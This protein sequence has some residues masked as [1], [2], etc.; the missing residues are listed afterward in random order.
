M[1]CLVLAQPYTFE[2]K[3]A[4]IPLVKP[5]EALVRVRR[6]GVC[7]T[8][9]HAFQGQQPYFNYPR[10][11]GHELAV[12]IVDVG[13][14]SAGLKNGN[15]CVVI[16]Y[17]SCG[18]CVACHAGKTNCCTSLKVLGVHVDG[19]LQDYLSVPCANLIK[20]ER[21]TLEQAALIENQSIGAHAVRRAEIKTGETVLVLGAGP[22]G[23]GI[24]QFAKLRGARVIAVD[25]NDQRL[26]FCRERLG[27][28]HTL[29]AKHDPA[30]EL[31]ALTAGDFPTA[32]FDATGSPQSMMRAFNYTAHGGRLIL[33]SIVQAEITFS[34]PDFHKRELTLLSSRNATREDF[35]NVIHSM[36]T[37]GIIGTD[38]ISQR[39]PFEQIAGEFPGWLNPETRGVKGIVEM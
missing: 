15:V 33:V 27:V 30:S 21:L 32:V 7:G 10:I 39:V 29:N 19:G 11:L 8:D 34:D 1:R 18:G 26:A 9:L 14:N 13:E 22:I 38:L 36:E 5:G 3:E 23:L 37:G 2:L 31:K 16:P 28:S 24:M 6:V 17:L 12:E 4:D 35:E 20:T 25:V